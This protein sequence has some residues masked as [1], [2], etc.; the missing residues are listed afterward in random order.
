M[1]LLA[2]AL[3]GGK[4]RFPVIRQTLGD[5]NLQPGSAGERSLQFVAERGRSRSKKISTPKLAEQFGIS[6][7]QS[8]SQQSFAQTST[9]SAPTKKKRI[10]R[11]ND[12]TG[13]GAGR[14]GNTFLS[15]SVS[16]IFAQRQRLGLRTGQRSLLSIR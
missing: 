3:G 14:I 16:D 5:P 8:S 12:P 6:S 11:T 9:A 7:G 1:C 4:P 13:L 10:I 2:A 15:S